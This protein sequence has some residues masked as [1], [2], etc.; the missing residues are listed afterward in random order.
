MGAYVVLA[1]LRQKPMG[2]VVALIVINLVIGFTGN[3]EW[4]AHIGGLLIGAALAFAFHC[5]STLRDRA[6]DIAVT[7]GASVVTLGLLVLLLTSVAPGHVNV[8]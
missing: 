5:A 8:T 7:V 3:I 6:Q 1:R 2:P 4:Q